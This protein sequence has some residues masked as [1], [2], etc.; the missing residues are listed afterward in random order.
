MPASKIDLLTHHEAGHAAVAYS[1]G[2]RLECVGIDTST[3][4]GFTTLAEGVQPT[5]LQHVLI[6]LAGGRAETVLDHTS[7]SRSYAAA[8]DEC[9]LQYILEAS[10]AHKLLRQSLDY[11]DRLT[12]RVD[13][14]L[15]GCCRRLVVL[16]WPAI[17][18]LASELATA[19][20]IGGAYAEAILDNEGL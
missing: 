19:H 11:C 4:D 7:S 15:A 18:R 16:H 1:F 5:R 13:E 14:R 2:L 9:R 3:Y 12:E 6:L 17:Q 20:Q 8:E 10:F